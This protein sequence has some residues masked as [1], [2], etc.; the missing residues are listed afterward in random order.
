VK[1]LQEIID[2]N[3]RHRAQEMPWFGQEIMIQAQAKGPL[4]EKKYLDELA[5]DQKMSRTDGIDATMD[6]NNLDAIIA[7]TGGPAWVTDLVNGDHF[8]GASST[9]AAVAG[10]PNINVP[11][12]F[13]HEL[14]IGISFFGKAWSE[15]TLIKLAYAF[16]QATKVRR[17]PKFVPT[18]GVS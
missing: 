16:E 8:S 4:T 13:S 15:P 3:D 7:P 10:Y 18:L 14:P 5:Q 9:P 17:P 12:G 2:F 6:K 1:S 11:A